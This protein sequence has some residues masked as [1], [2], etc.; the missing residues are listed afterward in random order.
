[1]ATGFFHLRA[2]PNGPGKTAANLIFF[3]GLRPEGFFWFWFGLVVAP[4]IE[5][6]A[7]CGVEYTLQP[8]MKAVN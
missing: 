7:G 6:G 5:P 3:S 8:M 2:G 4:G 1:M